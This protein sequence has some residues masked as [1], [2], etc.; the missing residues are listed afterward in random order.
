[1]NSPWQDLLANFAIIA[2][3][4]SIWTISEQWFYAWSKRRRD[5][6]FGLLCGVGTL[7]LIWLPFHLDAGVAIDLRAT[8]IAV[9]GLFGGIV[10]VLVTAFLALVC[11]FFIGGTGM[12]IGFFGITVASVVGIA[13]NF[14][15]KNRIPRPF[16]IL[17]FSTVTGT[18]TSLNFFL[19]PSERWND[20]LPNVGAPLALL[21]FSS[22]MLASFVL[23]QG[24]GREEVI[25]Q[26][27]MFRSIIDAL[28]DCLCAR[29]TE[30]RFIAANPATARLL[31]AASVEHLIGRTDAD[32]FPAA[33]AEKFGRDEKTVLLTN[34]PATFEQKIGPAEGPVTWLATLKAPLHDKAGALIGVISH[35][36]EVT[37]QK[38]FELEFEEN[39]RRLYDA[40]THMADALVM[41]DRDGRLVFSNEQYLRLFPLTADI[42][43]PGAHIRDI[44]RIAVERGEEE[45]LGKENPA[46]VAERV[47]ATFG[48]SGQRL[49][50][51]S[52][53][54]WLE[55]RT[56][57]TR[58]GACLIV[59]SDITRIKQAE[60]RLEEIAHTDSLTGLANRRAFDRELVKEAARTARTKTPLSLLLIDLDHFKAFNDTYG[61]PEG[62]AC[63]REVSGCISGSLRRATDLGA[64]YGGEEFAVIL[65]GTDIDGAIKVADEIR[66]R[67]KA[68]GITHSRSPSG[69]VTMSIGIAC[70][71]GAADASD[72]VTILAQADAALYEAKARGRDRTEL[73]GERPSGEVTWLVPPHDGRMRRA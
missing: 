3:I 47:A 13:G 46:A 65:P 64:R 72:P 42:R 30:G 14:I 41:F 49:I 18:A 37:A 6:A 67:L 31:G 9:S 70:S 69:F 1:M 39:R 40:L 55:A 32:F 8:L 5:F 16:D 25:N 7:A 54:R 24:R 34:R 43:V 66:Q 27:R 12:W 63:L 62:D 2:I 45:P 36:R 58:K 23:A 35:N 73:W 28:P 38:R 19:A 4:F 50:R 56:R 33:I 51:L 68:L 11:R 52:D 53:G 10:S 61:H 22:T 57:P 29:D 21:V 26:N 15:L 59:F 20:L 44:V 17:V 71:T 48:T 60:M